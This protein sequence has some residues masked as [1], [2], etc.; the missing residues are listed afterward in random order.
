MIIWLPDQQSQ[1][2]DT[3]VPA[4]QEVKS[5]CFSAYGSKRETC[6][7][8]VNTRKIRLKLGPTTF[9]SSSNFPPSG[10]PTN[11]PGMVVTIRAHLP[12]G[13]LW[14]GVWIYQVHPVMEKVIG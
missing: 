4:S 3:I 10:Q 8:Q 9:S 5:M 6:L 14:T 2:K 13:P 12:T 1:N 7:G 11:H